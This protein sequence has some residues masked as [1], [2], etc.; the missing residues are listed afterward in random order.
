[1]IA[2]SKLE[3]AIRREMRD[4]VGLSGG[5]LSAD[6]ENLKNAYY[7]AGYA[8]DA[9][10]AADGWSTYVDRTV[11]ETVEWAKGPLL[12]VFAGSDE[13]IRFE[14]CRPE[15]EQHARDATDYVNKVVFGRNAFDL[16][17]GPLT[18]GLYQR[19]GFAL[20]HSNLYRYDLTQS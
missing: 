6:R 17:Y 12:K 15:E 7:G 8:V 10:R 16:V 1:M 13:L 5:K 2:K 9:K 20:R 14:P 11:M 18:D 19:V 4:C 3:S